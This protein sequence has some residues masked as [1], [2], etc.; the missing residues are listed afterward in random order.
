MKRIIMWYLSSVVLLGYVK[1]MR[2]GEELVTRTWLDWIRVIR[3]YRSRKELLV[4]VVR[5]AFKGFK[6]Y[7]YEPNDE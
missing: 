2:I 3:E 1:G 6:V 7:S 4:N 5:D